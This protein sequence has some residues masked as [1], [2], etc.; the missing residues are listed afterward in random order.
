[1]AKAKKDSKMVATH[2]VRV[3]LFRLKGAEDHNCRTLAKMSDFCTKHGFKMCFSLTVFSLQSIHLR[4]YK[5]VKINLSGET[6]SC[7]SG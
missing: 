1:M 5:T 6:P 2:V 4:S 7:H 3:K